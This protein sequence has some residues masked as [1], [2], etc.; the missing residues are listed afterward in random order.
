MYPHAACLIVLAAAAAGA[1]GQGPVIHVRGETRQRAS[2]LH[3]ASVPRRAGGGASCLPPRWAPHRMP[4]PRSAAGATCKWA[5]A[6][7]AT[8][9]EVAYNQGLAQGKCR[10]TD[11][12]LL[13]ETPNR[14]VLPIN[15]TGAFAVS[16]SSEPRLLSAPRVHFVHVPK[17]GGTSAVT[18][19][20]AIMCHQFQASHG[21]LG[22]KDCCKPGFCQLDLVPGRSRVCQTVAGCTGHFPLLAAEMSKPAVPSLIML[23]HPVA[24]SVSGWH[25]HGHNPNADCYLSAW[26]GER[27]ATGRQGQGRYTFDEYVAM[28]SYQNIYTQML[29]FDSHPYLRPVVAD[30]SMAAQYLAIGQARLRQMAF[31][32]VQEAMNASLVLMRAE[33]GLA[34]SDHVHAPNHY[35]SSR[36]A[37]STA[38]FNGGGGAAA[39]AESL[40]DS[41]SSVNKRLREAHAIDIQLYQTAVELF[42]SRL[43]V[44]GLLRHPV[45]EADLRQSKLCG[46][47]AFAAPPVAQP[48]SAGLRDRENEGHRSPGDL[49]IKN[50][51]VSDRS[52]AEL[53]AR[54][55]VPSER[56]RCITSYFH[57]APRTSPKGVNGWDRDESLQKALIMNRKACT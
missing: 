5:H 21:E 13:T 44:L 35:R 47:P 24:R 55:S 32:G 41:G 51:V 11:G 18:S 3:K 22:S 39:L 26:H 40:A 46:Q 20:R 50:N 9:A 28:P 49:A 2:Q 23:R 45:V 7:E 19:L 48:P 56:P 8:R 30:K 38:R 36:D 14:A 1:A 12:R 37:T 16:A 54:R 4:P 43:R 10:Y 53:A 15:L 17:C 27:P 34:G 52:A 25:F 31:V 57:V 42:C 29:G 6:A 33:F